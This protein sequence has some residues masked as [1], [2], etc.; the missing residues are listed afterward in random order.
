MAL[1]VPDYIAKADERYF[2]EWARRKGMRPY[3]RVRDEKHGDILIADSARLITGLPSDR[4][5][6]RFYR[7]G[8]CL[9]RAKA[10]IASSWDYDYNEFPG[11]TR[12][13]KQEARIN[14]ALE[15]ARMYFAQFEEH[16]LFNPNAGGKFSEMIH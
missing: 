8:F 15:Y 12:R 13:G 10:W 6:E 16:R 1:I 7:T 5:L 9:Y 3:L 2:E 4:G 11:K 14:E